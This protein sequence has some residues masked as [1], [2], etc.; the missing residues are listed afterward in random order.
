M[1]KLY[2]VATPIENLEDITFRALDDLKYVDIISWYDPRKTL[3]LLN[4]YDIKKKLVAY[5]KFNEIEKSKSLIND[6]KKD[7]DIA[8]V[9]DAGT[10]CI[11]DPGYILVKEAH[12]NGIEVIAI[13]GASASIS[14][15]SVSGLDTKQF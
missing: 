5:H 6:L 3:K 4:H 13:P 15:L 12:E 1:G 8:I 9:T 2:V 14:S 11:S 7:L 10:P